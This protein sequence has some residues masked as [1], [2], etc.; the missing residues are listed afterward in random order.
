MF[1]HYWAHKHTK[2]VCTHKKRRYIRSASPHIMPTTDGLINYIDTEA[3]CRHLKILTY[4]GTLRPVSKF[5]VW[6]YSQSC[7]YFRSSFVS[8]CPSPLL[9]GSTLP[10]LPCVNKYTVFRY[11]VCKGGGCGYGVQGLRQI[12][13]CR[14][15]PLLVNF[16]RWRHFALPSM[17]LIYKPTSFPSPLL[18]PVTGCISWIC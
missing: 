10:P 16:I 4:K 7:W 5:I 9:S 15:V 18:T 17:S 12:N 3:K 2:Y 8:F 6:I 13:T 14:K 11:T 1:T